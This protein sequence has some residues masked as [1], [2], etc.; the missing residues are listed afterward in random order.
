MKI[1]I[2]DGQG[3]GIGKAL[4]ERFKQVMPRQELLAVGTNSLAT[5]A[6]LR[7]GADYGATG[8]NPV[9]HNS[10]DANLIIGPMGIVV[11]NSL[12]GELS[13]AMAQSIGES[14]ATKIL[15][16]INKCNSIVI[17]V[18]ELLLAEYVNK[19]VAKAAELMGS[20]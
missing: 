11:A 8:E 17:G 9:L 7:A 15:I 14:R 16:P 5:A 20:L 18:E 19:A 2:V 1:M 13:P 4:V 3:G 10:K 6:M 12:Y